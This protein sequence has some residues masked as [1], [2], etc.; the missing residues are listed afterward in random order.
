M[1]RDDMGYWGLD[2]L[3]VEPC[4][5]VKFYPEIEVCMK[6]ITMEETEKQ[7]EIERESL[8]DFGDSFVGRYRKILWN[9]FEYPSTSTAAKFNACFSLSMV[10]VST[11]CFVLSTLIEESSSSTITPWS[12]KDDANKSTTQKPIVDDGSAQVIAAIVWVDAFTAIYFTIEYVVRFACSPKKL[13]FFID[14][15]NLVDLFAILPYFLSMVLE[16]LSEFHIIGKTGKV[17]RLVRVTRILR[18]FKLVRHFAGLQ[19]LFS[20]LVAA[21]KELGLLIM[22]VGV[23]VLTFSSLIYFAEKDDQDWS[24]M[25]AFWWGLLTIT[26]VGYGTV[27]PMTGIGKIIGG[28][29]ALMGVFTITLPVPIMVNNFA[30][31]YKNKLW[32]G[33]VALQRRERQRQGIPDANPKKYSTVMITSGEKGSS[34]ERQL[35]NEVHELNGVQ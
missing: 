16:H 18:V 15:M 33:E 30:M 31:F 28:I 11:A 23:T 13:K 29:C 32:R 12:A 7:R 14:P 1:T 2:E 26:T 22:L 9:L 24:F 6:E 35:L 20:T 4:C 21:C 5:A 19:S 10:V 8:E 3:T 17:L 25:E 27:T 34:K